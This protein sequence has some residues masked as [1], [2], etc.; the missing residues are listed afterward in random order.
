LGLISSARTTVQSSYSVLSVNPLIPGSK[1]PEGGAAKTTGDTFTCNSTGSVIGLS[2]LQLSILGLFSY[3]PPA[4]A[5]LATTAV[6]LYGSS[7]NPPG[8]VY[9]SA[10][11][12]AIG[13][14]LF[15]PVALQYCGAE[16]CGS[17]QNPKTITTTAS[18]VVV[19]GY[20]KVA[21][22]NFPNYLD[23]T[24]PRMS[25]LVSNAGFGIPGEA[26]TESWAWNSDLTLMSYTDGN[27]NI[28]IF[29]NYD[30][31]GNP[32]I[33][34]EATNSTTPRYT[35]IEYHPVLSRPLSISRSSISNSPFLNPNAMHTITFD[36]G[37]AYDPVNYNTG[38]L[39]NFVHQIIENGY[40]PTAPASPW[41]AWTAQTHI[42]EVQYGTSSTPAGSHN[43]V[44]EISGPTS[45]FS[46]YGY[47]STGYL[48]NE[49]HAT[50]YI[51]GLLTTYLAYDGNGRVLGWDD[52]NGNQA[53]NTYDL[54][55]RLTSTSLVPITYSGGTA[56]SGTPAVDTYSYDLVGN[57]I[58]HVTPGGTTLNYTYDDLLRPI[59]SSAT[60]QSASYPAWTKTA[61]Y[62]LI[63]LLGYGGTQGLT[64]RT[65]AGAPITM[66]G[67]S[68]TEPPVCSASGAEQL[69]SEVSFDQFNRIA[70]LGFL[71]GNNNLCN[72]GIYDSC[73][74]GYF[75]SPGGALEGQSAMQEGTSQGEWIQYTYDGLNR[76]GSI[77]TYMS[78]LSSYGVLTNPVTISNGQQATTSL[79]PITNSPS[80][81][82]ISLAHDF[83]N[84]I[85]GRTDAAGL[86]T[87]YLYDDFGNAVEMSSPDTG[88]WVNSYDNSGNLLQTV[89][90]NGST[91]TYTYDF[92]DRVVSK[93]GTLLVNDVPVSN[94]N[95][96]VTYLYDEPGL[97][98]GSVGASG[99]GNLAY[100]NTAGKLT[101]IL[102]QDDSGN[103]I[104]THYNYDF[105]GWII[106]EVDERI[107]AGG[108]EQIP[109][110]F[111][112]QSN[113][114]WGNDHQLLSL[115]YQN[116]KQITYQYLNGAVSPNGTPL[117]SAI[118][119]SFASTAQQAVLTNINY[120][121]DGVPQS[122]SFGNGAAISRTRNKR[123]EVTGVTS[124]R[125]INQIL[126]YGPNQV[127]LPTTIVS[128][129]IGGL[130]AATIYS[131]RAESFA[132]N[133]IGWI[134][135]YSKAFQCC[136][137]VDVGP[138]QSFNWTYDVDGNRIQEISTGAYGQGGTSSY[139]FYLGTNQLWYSSG[140][141]NEYRP[142]FESDNPNL[143]SYL[144]YDANGSLTASRL[145][146]DDINGNYEW[147]SYR[148]NALRHP[149][150][151]DLDW[152]LDFSPP[153]PAPPYTKV[154]R[155]YAYDGSGR[156]WQREDSVAPTGI[157]PVTSAGPVL[158]VE[159]VPGAVNS[160][161][162]PQCGQ[163]VPG[164]T[165]YFYDFQ[166]RL[167]QEFVSAPN[168]PQ[169]G[170][171]TYNI[172]DHVY[173]GSSSVEIAQITRTWMPY[174]VS[175]PQDQDI[176]F[177]HRDGRG[178]V[179]A[180]DSLV[181]STPNGSV[182][183]GLVWAAERSP[184][185][186]I[187]NQGLPG[188]DMF[189]GT[190]DDVQAVEPLSNGLSAAT[191]DGQLESLGLCAN[192]ALGCVEEGQLDPSIGR[193]N[194]P[195]VTFDASVLNPY[196]DPDVWIPDAGSGAIGSGSSVL[197]GSGGALLP[198]FP[199][200]VDGGGPY[201]VPI[202]MS[203]PDFLSW[204]TAEMAQIVS[205]GDSVTQV[206]LIRMQMAWHLSG[207]W[208]I[209]SGAAAVVTFLTTPPA[210]VGAGLW[211][212]W[213][214]T[215]L[216]RGTLKMMKLPKDLSRLSDQL[217]KDRTAIPPPINSL[218]PRFKPGHLVSDPGFGDESYSIPGAGGPGPGG[219]SQPS[220]AGPGYLYFD[221]R[222]GF[223]GLDFRNYDPPLN[224][225]P[226]P[227]SQQQ[228]QQ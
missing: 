34:G 176:Q 193:A 31:H 181:K 26:P 72:Q 88:T 95:D 74:H 192:G 201:F 61:T 157:P 195:S 139:R 96:S 127:G 114:S 191:T 28:S 52:P 197:G 227:S 98:P 92:L 30:T 168:L 117:P 179:A 66:P 39:T 143:P 68:T 131:Q 156:L 160:P 152:Q 115:I 128:A 47:W 182:T 3:V 215:G 87:N 165:Q 55:G 14:S 206:D 17:S 42:V 99:N 129:P 154:L 147:L 71:D 25:S 138:T 111:S 12:D 56:I 142:T 59:S 137:G 64:L 186:Q 80:Y 122:W 161:G 216:V 162:P 36:Y 49:F 136:G 90:A 38:P 15:N 40:V 209:A 13:H 51:A 108:S 2:N 180:V 163:P 69:C 33:I 44:S 188:P 159:P 166:G 226:P 23:A 101:S 22:I 107:G 132:Y 9:F 174:T 220:S 119:T 16:T 210:D 35:T 169:S 21:T 77:S 144:G 104:N 94:A 81:S 43:Q 158:C 125:W 73:V 85:I 222:I 141:L 62:G 196:V 177:L 228:E 110:A 10:A 86:Q 126:S 214:A 211:L 218:P 145:Y 149:S 91:V 189:M 53:V 202:W 133:A 83:N 112:L 120:F 171:V 164:F 105:H 123:G 225:P 116:G 199:T 24:P 173:L 200:V 118:F 190:S 27:G 41:G 29:Y 113:Y 178:Y 185:G 167:L 89:D 4:K 50:G 37:S 65:F 20:Q 100:E 75:Y 82:I 135:S 203:L 76:P 130:A 11:L 134:T 194:V 60:A 172:V 208:N 223:W 84:R 78:P 150:E 109:P 217:A 148:Y 79:A 153:A 32:Q 93:I 198:G 212:A 70:A 57:L 151:I 213:R 1:I 221:A 6:D 183:A 7:T 187:L 207:T 97:I 140:T 18:L 219:P 46:T 204:N 5:E 175:N 102:T 205:P 170:P 67:L 19:G 8:I 58:Q 184:F 48:Q 63:P 155:T 124:G 103:K 224:Q 146:T 45:E 121:V 106:N 54:Q